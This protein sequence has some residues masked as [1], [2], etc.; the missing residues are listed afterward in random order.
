IAAINVLEVGA[1]VRVLN[2]DPDSETITLTVRAEPGRNGAPAAQA[3]EG[4]LLII[5]GGPEEVD[6]LRWWQVETAGGTEGW[7]V[8]GLVNADRDDAY[9]RTLL[10][11]CPAEG[12][13]LT[14]RFGDYIVTT[15]LDGSDPCVLDYI[16]VSAWTTFSHTTFGFDNRFVPSPDGEYVLYTDGM[17]GAEGNSTLY[18][19]NRDGSERLA[20]TD[21]MNV[22]WAAW[23]PDGQRIAI[24]NGQQIAMMRPDGSSY[25]VLA[26]EGAIYSWVGW[27]PDSETIV[28]AEQSR[29][30]DQ[31]GTAIEYAFYRINI[32]E[33]GLRE[34]LRTMLDISSNPQISP[35]GSTLA[36]GGLEYSLIDGMSGNT[37]VQFY[38]EVLGVVIQ[39]ID[40]ETDELVVASDEFFYI[41]TWLPNGRGILV[42]DSYVLPANG[43]AP[44][45]IEFSDDLPEAWNFIGWESDTVFLGYVGYGFEIEPDDYGI[46]AVDVTTGQVERRM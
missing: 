45:V 15:G 27:L 13:R 36:I 32:L 8:E 21:N 28:Y 20:L 22:Y 19:L 2:D 5:I 29:W 41:T 44:S 11:V 14:L 1:Q 23:S 26:Q 3:L 38:D 4:D 42:S 33:G 18:R 31:M 24:A 6:G 43:G 12:E 34:I 46:W 25:G 37:P 39:F 40:L 35:D 9:E 10:A 17:Y 16:S 30:Q 7:V